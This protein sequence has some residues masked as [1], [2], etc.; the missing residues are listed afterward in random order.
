MIDASLFIDV[1]VKEGFSF[2]TG[3]P[4]SILTPL[5]NEAICSSKLEYVSAT[6]E[7][8]AVGIAAGAHLSDK[9]TVVICQN[10]GL[11]NTVNPLTSLNEPFR[12]PTLLIV[13]HRG[14]PGTNDEPQHKLM[15]T[16]T[17]ELLD[18]LKIPWESFPQENKD[19]ENCLKRA[20]KIMNE[21]GLPYALLMKKNTVS[22]TN[23]V[24]P[25]NK[26]TTNNYLPTGEFVE[27]SDDNLTRMKAISLLNEHYGRNT[28]IIATTGKTGRELFSTGYADNHLYIVGSMGCASGI[29]L[30]LRL[31]S[32]NKKNA[33]V[34]LDGDGAALMKMGTIATIG[35][36]LPEQFIHIVLDNGQY[37]STGGQLTSSNNVDFAAVASACGYNASYR[38]N[39]KKMVMD[40]LSNIDKSKSPTLIHLKVSVKTSSTLKRPDITPQQVK[41]N[42]IKWWCN[43]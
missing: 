13:T 21:T 18:T 14:E 33:V 5:I 26:I 28:A 34:V 16:I 40:I 2:W 24:V 7:G 6:S 3:V 25:Q 29:G 22:K 4:C 38:A 36:Y 17:E 30:G 1:A 12:I 42:F 37:E 20:K 9:Q 35:H 32:L 15:G 43:K 27:S 10:S 19:V 39:T 11:G 8:E 41:N 31:S 23:K